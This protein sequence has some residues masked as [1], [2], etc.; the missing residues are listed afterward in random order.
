MTAVSKSSA[1]AATS[2]EPAISRRLS[3]SSTPAPTAKAPV[4]AQAQLS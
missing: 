3:S 4:S 2:G 1:S